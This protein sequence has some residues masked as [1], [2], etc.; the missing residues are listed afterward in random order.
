MKIENGKENQ[1]HIENEK[2]NMHMNKKTKENTIKKRKR[3]YNFVIEYDW[4]IVRRNS[5]NIKMELKENYDPTKWSKWD[6]KGILIFLWINENQ[7]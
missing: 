4:Q 7:E 1:I 6:Q 2:Q 3:S 5:K